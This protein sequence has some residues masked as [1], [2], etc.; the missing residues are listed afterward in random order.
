MRHVL[1]R[2][3]LLF[4]T[5]FGCKFLTYVFHLCLYHRYWTAIESPCCSASIFKTLDS[6]HHDTTW[7]IAPGGLA[8]TLRSRETKIDVASRGEWAVGDAKSRVSGEGIWG[9]WNRKQRKDQRETQG[10]AGPKDQLVMRSTGENT[11]TQRN[12]QRMSTKHSFQYG[13]TT[14]AR[15]ILKKFCLC[16]Q[17]SRSFV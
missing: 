4:L 13:P 17:F 3:W 8:N 11:N 15:R 2:N 14:P 9:R 7:R 12:L 16:G 6:F 10:V 5:N 1:Q